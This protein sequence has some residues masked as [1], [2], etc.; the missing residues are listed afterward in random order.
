MKVNLLSINLRKIKKGKS[1][2]GATNI[3]RF[4][5]I[6]FETV[7]KEIKSL[8]IRFCRFKYK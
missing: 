5:K 6:I 8:S 1:P 4:F 3:D 7:K 2:M